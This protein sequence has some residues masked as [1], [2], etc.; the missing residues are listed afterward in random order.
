MIKKLEQGMADDV[1]SIFENLPHY[2]NPLGIARLKDDIKKY[3]IENPPIEKEGFFVYLEKEK[4]L[5]LIGYKRQIHH[6]E[7]EITWLAVRKDV[8]RRGIGRKLITHLED[9]LSQYKLEKTTVVIPDDIVS[10]EFYY[11]MG[12]K[13]INRFLDGEG[14]KLVY[15][16][17]YGVIGDTCQEYIA[18]YLRR[19]RLR[20]IKKK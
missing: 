4:P 12:F 7:Y 1:V 18:E 5:G 6:M 16:K 10:R 8:Q 20:E 13:S 3:L 15:E 2:F 17:R 19:K 11:K 9:F 14:E